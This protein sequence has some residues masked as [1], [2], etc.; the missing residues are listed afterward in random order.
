MWTYHHPSF[1]LYQIPALR[2]NY[3]YMVR[4]TLVGDPTTLIIDPGEAQ[5]VINACEPLGIIPTHIFN[6]HHHW[7]HTDGNI[8]LKERYHCSVVGYK[9]DAARIPAIDVFVEASA[10]V[11]IGGLP[12]QII[13]TPGH[14]HG[15]IVL[16]IDDALFCGD[17]IFGAGCGRVFEGTC[18]EMWHSLQKITALDPKTSIYCAHEY[19]LANL[20]F[21]NAIRPNLQA[22]TVRT[23]YDQARRAQ[24]LP[25]IPTTVGMEI[26]TN[27]FLWPMEKEFCQDYTRENQLNF[28]PTCTARSEDV[29][30]HLRE[31]R[32]HF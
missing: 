27:P 2:D 32:N 17:L 5:C 19:T 18:T 22:L 24:D 1:E 6:T 20:A 31:R 10:Q 8:P 30:T 4:S 23:A 21:A 16:Q 29:F 14:T 26:A 7:D 13:A 15:H 28:P 12:A 11:M 25:T 9:H 3:I